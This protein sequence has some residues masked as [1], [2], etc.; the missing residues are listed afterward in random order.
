MKYFLISPSLRVRGLLF[1]LAVSKH[2]R[3]HSCTIS[4]LLGILQKHWGREIKGVIYFG[5]QGVFNAFLFA[6]N[7]K[8]AFLHLKKD[9]ILAPLRFILSPRHT[10]GIFRIQFL[11]YVIQENSCKIL[12]PSWTSSTSHSLQLLVMSCLICY[13]VIPHITVLFN[14]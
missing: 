3:W 8:S 5:G 2:E 4:I 12:F 14:N 13:P 9:E 10:P 7:L 11:A 6:F 1:L